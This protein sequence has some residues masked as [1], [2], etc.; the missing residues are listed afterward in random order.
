MKVAEWDRAELAIDML[1]NRALVVDERQ[2]FDRA[3]ERVIG[4]LREKQGNA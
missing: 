4:A 2:L 1:H 3:L